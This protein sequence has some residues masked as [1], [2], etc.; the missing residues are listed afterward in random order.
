MVQFENKGL[1]ITNRKPELFDDLFRQYSKPLFYYAAKF[2]D[3]EIARD[4][5]QD[6]FV[7]LWADQSIIVKQSLNAL[8]FTMI[9][10]SCLQQLEKQKVRNK[11]FESAK[12]K[13]Q[14]EELRFYMEEKTSLLEQEL[15]NKL[16]EVL[17]NL[18]DRCRQVFAMS[19]FDN[20][21]NKEIAEE[22]DISVKAVEKQ[23]T[24]ALATI[25]TEMKDYLP[26][27]VFLSGHLFKN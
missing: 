15:E 13:L 4:I 1:I 2:V 3:E 9:R 12:L 5:V 6:V 21:K 22:L 11:Y 20:K 16:N 8:L 27:L 17:N 10:N 19:R 14:E 7:K 24:K 18:P 25:R 23:I 26:L